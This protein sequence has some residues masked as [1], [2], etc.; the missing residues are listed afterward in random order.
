MDAML[1][2]TELTKETGESIRHFRTL[3]GL[4]QQ[5]LADL[6]GVSRITLNRL[7]QG[8]QLPDFGIICSIA[9][10]LQVSVADLRKSKMLS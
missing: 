10:V 4:S 1:D 6:A 2:R 3:R 8:H 5:A 9:D 7:E